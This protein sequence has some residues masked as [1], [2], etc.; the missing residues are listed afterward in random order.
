MLYYQIMETAANEMS[1]AFTQVPLPMYI[2][3]CYSMRCNM[4]SIVKLYYLHVGTILSVY[5]NSTN[6]T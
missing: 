3:I 1:N 4:L 5:F 2:Y 6:I